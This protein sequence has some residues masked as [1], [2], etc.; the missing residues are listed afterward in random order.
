MSEPN[1]GTEPTQDMIDRADARTHQHI[2]RVRANLLKLAAVSDHSDE[3]RKRSEVHDAS[4]FGP[5]ERIPYVWL[6]EFHHCRR[7]GI[8]FEYPAGIEEQ[9]R[10]AIDHHVTTNR[11][12]YQFHDSPEDMT[13]VDLIEMVCDWTAMSQEFNADG[14]SARAW[15]DKTINNRVHLSETKRDFVYRTIDRLDELNSETA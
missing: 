13:D 7:A 15:A 10:Q 4:K 8:P 6:N 9:V 11:H 14:G 3:L 12:H 2:D 1:H 5:E